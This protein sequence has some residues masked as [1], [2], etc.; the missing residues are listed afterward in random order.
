MEQTQKIPLI[1]REIWELSRN[2]LSV[3]YPFFRAALHRFT[4]Q[5][6]AGLQMPGFN[7]TAVFYDPK[8]L[9]QSYRQNPHIPEQTLLHMLLHLLYLHPLLRPTETGANSEPANTRAGLPT[10]SANPKALYHPPSFDPLWDLA[11]DLSVHRILTHAK[12]ERDARKIY[13]SLQPLSHGRMDSEMTEMLPDTGRMKTGPYYSSPV[14]QQEPELSLCLDDH[15][16][17]SCTEPE[18]LLPHISQMWDTIKKEKGVGFGGSGSARGNSAGHQTE[19]I[20]LKQK[21]A[22][23]FRRYLKRFA[24][25]REEIKLDT[26]SFDY[27]PYMYGLEHYGN[28]PLIEHL[29]Y[30]EVY[31]LEELVIAIDTSGSC[32]ADTVRRFMEATYTI[33]SSREN[34]FRK[35]N[36][37]ILQCDFYV[38]HAAHITCEEDWK[39]YLNHL[40]IHGRSG[41][42]FRPVFQYIEKLREDKKLKNLK[43]LLYFTDGDGI[44]P[45]KPTDYETAFIFLQEKPLHQKVPDWARVFLLDGGTYEY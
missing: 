3:T 27:I 9:I 15:R 8:Q 43:A 2:S 21:Q 38:Q 23:R 40:T 4:F 34:F 32:S 20:S 39:A 26:E 1:C 17:W 13:A 37:Y 7:G 19:Q 24:I 41:T 6:M 33:L 28:M 35:M 42:D 25:A 44:Y 36:L 22:D 14:F 12:E 29:E 5:E 31:R 16:F 30:Q 10:C 11:C 45:E 18:K